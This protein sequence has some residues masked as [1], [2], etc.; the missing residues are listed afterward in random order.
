MRIF[1]LC[2]W[3]IASCLLCDTTLARQEPKRQY[4]LAPEE[5]TLVTVASQSTSPLRI[6]RAQLL[7]NT[8][9]S[10]D[11]SFV[12][13]LHNQSKKPIKSFSI[14]FVTSEGTG[15][16]INDRRLDGHLLLPAQT[17]PARL[18]TDK[19]DV[20]SL[21]EAL[22]KTLKLETQMKVVVVLIVESVEFSDGTSFSDEK[23]VQALR[24]Y[25]QE[26]RDTHN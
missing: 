22:R 5:Q 8:K 3:L 25:F 12:Y 7:L 13:Q 14:V 1:I 21:N 10:W 19:G 23:A 9:T 20:V 26:L 24:R 2:F 16:T 17:I 15:G 6:E 4:V 11:F 18:E